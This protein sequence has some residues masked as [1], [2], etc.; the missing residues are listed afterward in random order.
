MSNVKT[1]SPRAYLLLGGDTE[2]GLVDASGRSTKLVRGHAVHAVLCHQ[3]AKAFAELRT[4]PDVTVRVCGVNV[5]WPCSNRLRPN[6]IAKRILAVD[7]SLRPG[8]CGGWRNITVNDYLLLA[9][10]TAWQ[11][12]DKIQALSW[13]SKHPVWPYLEF[14]SPFD[15]VSGS[16][17]LCS[18]LDP[19]SWVD[20][21]ERSDAADSFVHACMGRAP[22]AGSS[23]TAGG[24][25]IP[26]LAE[27]CRRVW[28]WS[29]A[30]S[31]SRTD[32]GAFLLRKA[33]ATI[34]RKDEMPDQSLRAA[35]MRFAHYLRA[36]WLDALDVAPGRRW[37]I[38]ER[39][40]S[41]EPDTAKAFRKEVWKE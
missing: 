31:A 6:E 1:S 19:R 13:V 29:T 23:A 5:L 3:N 33:E 17:I 37:F 7:E 34:S 24:Q 35:T 21:P 2:T 40:F 20:F 8:S 12:K 36:C 10:W 28:Q 25:P 9:T 16:V 26:E 32:P 41:T 11:R 27:A 22:S 15:Q 38:P 30:R 39:F 18:L 14:L 4:N